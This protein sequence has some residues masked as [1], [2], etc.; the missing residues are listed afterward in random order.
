MNEPSHRVIAMNGL[1]GEE[2]IPIGRSATHGEHLS[3]RSEQSGIASLR[4]AHYRL[5]S[6]NGARRKTVVHL[7][8]THPGLKN[9]RT[10]PARH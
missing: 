7:V 9:E 1:C 2:A 3:I 10:E 6:R 4:G 5:A 8:S